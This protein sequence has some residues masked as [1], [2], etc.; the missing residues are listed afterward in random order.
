[1]QNCQ[2]PKQR[3]KLSDETCYLIRVILKLRRIT[4]YRMWLRVWKQLQSAYWVWYGVW[5]DINNECHSTSEETYWL[6][7]VIQCLYTTATYLLSVWWNLL[8]NE[9]DSG[10]EETFCLENSIQFLYTTPKYLHSLMKWT[11]KL[12][13]ELEWFCIKGDLL[14]TE[15][16]SESEHHCH[17]LTGCDETC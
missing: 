16:D 4:V 14:L 5:W 11:M 2:L 8:H 12:I 9:W 1:V 3:Y 6:Q 10:S 15:C 13:T 17:L 7:N